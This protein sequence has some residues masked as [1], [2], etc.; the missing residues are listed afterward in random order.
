M[1]NIA[2]I[3]TSIQGEGS[4]TG[5]AATFIRFAG[6]NLDC[7]W[8]DTDHKQKK[9]MTEESIVREV[10]QHST[11]NI[12]ITGG[13]PT[14]QYG[15]YELVH[16]L[17]NKG[18][19]VAIETNGTHYVDMGQFECVTVS[20]KNVASTKQRICTDLKVVYVGQDLSIYF[21]MFRPQQFYLQPLSNKK[22]SIDACV[23]IVMQDP[24]WRLSLQTHKLIGVR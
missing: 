4:W 13:E 12:V 19:N 18:F 24:R 21:D 17:H 10:L 2:E 11:R 8:C 7:E 22:E 15:L 1:I 23:K 9:S 5:R 6:C 20:P 16:L 14:I 3:F